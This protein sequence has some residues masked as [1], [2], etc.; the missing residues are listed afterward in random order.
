MAVTDKEPRAATPCDAS[1]GIQPFA[2]TLID[3]TVSA[4]SHTGMVRLP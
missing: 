3:V 2:E 4:A 1:I